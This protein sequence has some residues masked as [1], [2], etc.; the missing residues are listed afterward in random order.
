MWRSLIEN[1]WLSLHLIFRGKRRKHLFGNGDWQDRAYSYF[2]RTM[3]GQSFHCLTRTRWY[4]RI[5]FYLNDLYPDFLSRNPFEEPEYFLFPYNTVTLDHMYLI[6][7]MEDRFDLLKIAEERKLDINRFL[8]YVVNHVY[9]LNEKL[10]KPKYQLM[11]YGS[12]KPAYVSV[13]GFSYQKVKRIN[14]PGKFVS[15]AHG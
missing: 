6:Y 12:T 13:K 8:N 15:R 10:D 14:I 3:V 9:S 7:Q 4:Y 11:H 2:M 1:S 5:A